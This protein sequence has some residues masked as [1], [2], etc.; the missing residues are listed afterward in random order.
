MSNIDGKNQVLKLLLV[1]F[2]VS[3]VVG[4][5]LRARI[6]LVSVRGVFRTMRN[7]YDKVGFFSKNSLRC[8]IISSFVKKLHHVSLR[9]LQIHLSR[10]MFFIYC[11]YNNANKKYEDKYSKV[12]KLSFYVQRI[13]RPL[14]FFQRQT[15]F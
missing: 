15:N 3:L 10:Y 13:S 2:A 11:K 12:F 5:D 14:K 1:T 6:T 4:L 9:G 8:K 7:I